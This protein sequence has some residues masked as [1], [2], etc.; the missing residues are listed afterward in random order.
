MTDLVS[1]SESRTWEQKEPC[2][3]SSAN[4]NVPEGSGLRHGNQSWG[5][6]EDAFL[7]QE[8]A[9][10]TTTTAI[11]KLLTWRG[12]VVSKNGV[13]GRANRIG[14]PAHTLAPNRSQVPLARRLLPLVRPWEKPRKEGCRYIEGEPNGVNTIW[15]D[16]PTG[17]DP[18]EPY[19]PRHQSVCYR[20]PDEPKFPKQ[21]LSCAS[22]SNPDGTRAA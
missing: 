20:A 11:A 1:L 22:R 4:I 10:G 7:R 17:E 19:C 18:G 8:W 2:M 21:D 13:I 12:F 14:L 3:H 9:K 16:A 5:E 15:C 6:S